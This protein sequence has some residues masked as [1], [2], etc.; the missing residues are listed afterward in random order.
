[1]LTVTA[2]DCKKGS[3]LIWGAIDDVLVTHFNDVWFR[4]ED[5]HD[6]WAPW[7]IKV[8]SA[9]NAFDNGESVSKLYAET[10]EEAFDK[11]IEYRKADLDFERIDKSI[12]D[13]WTARNSD[14]AP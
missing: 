14:I 12:K 8:T 3:G 9:N 11:V 4:V 7:V 13:Y 1:M 2:E 6:S 5:S 10:L